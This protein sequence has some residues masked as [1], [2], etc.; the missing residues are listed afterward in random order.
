MKIASLH[1][2]LCIKQY[3]NTFIQQGSFYQLTVN[4]KEINEKY[5]AA[6]RFKTLIIVRNV[7]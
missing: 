3:I 7:S 2:R 6:Q 5:Q 4:K 1:N